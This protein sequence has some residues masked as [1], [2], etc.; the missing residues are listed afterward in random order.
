M[1]TLPLE[2]V[3][4]IDFSW[5]VAG[6]F[7]TEMLALMGADVI[8]VESSVHT[9]I[10]RR[11]P[12]MADGVEGV[13]RSAMWH[14]LNTNKKSITLNLGNPEG[15]EI[16]KTLVKDADVAIE[17][18]SYGK[19]DAFGLGYDV[20][21]EVNPSLVMVRSSGLGL[22][23]PFRSYVTFGPPL[24]AYAGLASITGQ[25]GGTPERMVGGLWS[26]HQSGLA[27]LFGLLGALEHRSRT[28]E[29]QLVE[30]SMAEAIS[31][32]LID[33]LIE[34]GVSGEVPGP[35]GNS[36]PGC[37]PHGIYPADGDDVWVAIVV[38]E[39]E[40]WKRFVEN[41]PG[42]VWWADP[43]L[44]TVE[45]RLRERARIDESIAAWTR[46]K[47]AE[48]IVDL[49][50][51]LDI[52]AGRANSVQNLLEDEA[53][54]NRGFF[55]HEDHPE[56]G[57]RDIPGIGWRIDGID[58]TEVEHAPLLGEHNWEVLVEGLGMDPEEFAALVDRG[59]IV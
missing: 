17:N 42:P 34:Y 6:P 49:M 53:L 8:K 51:D 30:Y 2:G 54:R 7:C 12:P 10:M 46:D 47:T 52:S 25:E 35:A 33:A 55:L 48:E 31:A 21:Q 5:V 16:A 9:D 57:S 11:L 24:T 14:G 20:L 58:I 22:T 45:G 1:T 59:A 4:V 36:H 56:V 50:H 44:E 19:L 27:S 32:Q 3:R 40:Q 28:G 18:F 29:G 23:G 39:D 43:A 38:E 13:E 15:Q 26:D 37:C 41:V